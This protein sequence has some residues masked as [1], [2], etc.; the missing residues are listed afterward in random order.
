MPTIPQKLAELKNDG[1]TSITIDGH[2]DSVGSDEYHFAL[3]IKKSQC[4]KKYFAFSG[5]ESGK[6]S[7]VSYGESNPISDKDFENRRVDLNIK[8]T[9]SK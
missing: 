6:L 5:I 3:R 2:T 7:T 9:V 1:I 4:S 8:Y